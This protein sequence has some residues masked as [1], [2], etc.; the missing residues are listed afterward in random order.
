MGNDGA[1]TQILLKAKSKTKKQFFA[2][3]MQV[4]AE[5]IEVEVIWK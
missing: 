4:L 5:K 3:A 1:K 2:L